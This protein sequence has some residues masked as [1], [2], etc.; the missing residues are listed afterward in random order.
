MI[1]GINASVSALNAYGRKFQSTANNT[2]NIDTDGYKKTRVTMS[3]AANGSVEA[4][5]EKV[6]APGPIVSELTSEGS[7]LVE[8]SNVDLAQEVTNQILAARGYEANLASVKAF[9]EMLGS[10]L[11]L[12][13]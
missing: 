11:D 5:S 8:K 12:I 3:E 4:K 13:K 7:V 2:A 9:D 1:A 10:T 6:D